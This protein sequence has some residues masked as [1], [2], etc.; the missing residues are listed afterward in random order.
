MNIDDLAVVQA[1]SVNCKTLADDTLRISFDVLP[2]DAKVAFSLFGQ[3]GIH[4]AIALLAKEASFKHDN[5]FETK[6]TKKIVSK[7][8]QTPEIHKLGEKGQWGKLA[9]SLYRSGFFF[10]PKVLEALGSDKEYRRWINRQPSAFSGDFSEWT[11]DNEG[12]CI[13]AHVRRSDNAGTGYKP[14]YSCIPL[15]DKEH[16]L[17]HREG[18]SA[19][20]GLDWD[21]QKNHYLIE[22]ARSRF[23]EIFNVDSLT[24]IRPDHMV[25]W[26]TENDLMVFLPRIYKT[27]L[28]KEI[29]EQCISE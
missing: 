15:T 3:R 28:N 12:R 23:Y 13:A 8:S 18:E 22:W 19:L 17:Q 11:E 27:I 1:T 21:A 9:A 20:V 6:E 10:A 14:P 16:Q 2:K 7:E 5:T 25:N 4:A 26:C 24:K 29:D